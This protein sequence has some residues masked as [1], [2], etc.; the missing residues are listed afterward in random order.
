[1]ADLDVKNKLLFT[2]HLTLQEDHHRLEQR[3]N[4]L[5]KKI[6]KKKKKKVMPKKKKKGKRV[7][8]L[9]PIRKL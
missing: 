3:L 6:I 8:F 9:L 5:E 1:M 4:K 2:Q 7:T